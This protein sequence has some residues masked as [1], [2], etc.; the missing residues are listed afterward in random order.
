[1]NLTANALVVM[2]TSD[3]LTYVWRW[4]DAKKVTMNA[5]DDRTQ[6]SATDPRPMNVRGVR[7]VLSIDGLAE[8]VVGMDFETAMRAATRRWGSNPMRAEQPALVSTY[9]LEVSGAPETKLED[10]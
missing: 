6:F 5:P 3:G 1:M 4:V 8:G 9:Q 7:Y 2:Q 10:Q